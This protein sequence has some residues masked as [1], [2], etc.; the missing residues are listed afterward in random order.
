MRRLLLLV[1]LALG[2]LAGC[3]GSGSSDGRDDPVTDQDAGRFAYDAARPL[4]LSRA[5]APPTCST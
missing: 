2:L 4:D 1:L 5:R 3:G